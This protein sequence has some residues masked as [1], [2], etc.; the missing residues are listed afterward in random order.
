M[1]SDDLDTLQ[2]AVV[3]VSDNKDHSTTGHAR[4]SPPPDASRFS[5]PESSHSS[6]SSTVA[7]DGA[8]DKRRST[9]TPLPHPDA[10]RLPSTPS[11]HKASRAAA[12]DGVSDFKKYSTPPYTPSPATRDASHPRKRARN[13][14]DSD[15]SDFPISPISNRSSSQPP[16]PSTPSARH[17]DPRVPDQ[18]RRRCESPID[19]VTIVGSNQQLPSPPL[20]GRRSKRYVAFWKHHRFQVKG[21]AIGSY[22]LPSSPT[23][24][25]R[26]IHFRRHKKVTAESVATV[27]KSSTKPVEPE[28]SSRLSPVGLAQSNTHTLLSRTERVAT[29]SDVPARRP[30]PTGA[31]K[32][33]LHPSSSPG[34]EN[35][36]SH[37]VQNGKRKRD[38][39]D[40]G[41][42]P[43]EGHPSVMGFL[44]DVLGF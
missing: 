25:G 29:G 5:S 10:S 7:V 16:S 6:T 13:S 19:T 18:K 11:R 44:H 40:V 32:K 15:A 41:H 4:L 35:T 28:D 30:S 38:N 2:V 37:V 42:K 27:S 39:S 31:P 22:Q 8:P 14:V 34:G 23:P 33:S 20:S 12:V 26:G 36:G 43:E 9:P 24:S 1:A 21:T 3:A 17:S